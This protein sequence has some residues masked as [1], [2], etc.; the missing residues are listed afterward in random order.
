MAG[1]TEPYRRQIATVFH[2]RVGI[3]AYFISPWSGSKETP[4]SGFPALSETADRILKSIAVTPV[5]ALDPDRVWQLYISPRV[6]F[7]PGKNNLE[8]NFSLALPPGWQAEEIEIV[9]AQ[10]APVAR[11]DQEDVTSKI[12]PGAPE[13]E[14]RYF[15]VRDPSGY[16]IE[17]TEDEPRGLESP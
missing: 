17:L 14:R 10:M 9:D 11:P 7:A 5:A 1:S 6:T 3:F 13:V 8:A 15:V 4:W 12:R 2:D 16:L